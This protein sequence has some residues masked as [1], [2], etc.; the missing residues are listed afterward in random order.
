MIQNN[1]AKHKTVSNRS[2]LEYYRKYLHFWQLII[3]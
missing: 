1:Y 2:Q 3:P